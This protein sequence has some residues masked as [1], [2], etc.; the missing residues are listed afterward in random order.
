MKSRIT[1]TFKIVDCFNSRE[2]ETTLNTHVS[3]GW[4][5]EEVSESKSEFFHTWQVQ[6]IKFNLQK[7]RKGVKSWKTK[8]SRK[9]LN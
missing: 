6:F 1:P 9:R 8:K 3:A 5:V 4:K 2:L 7:E